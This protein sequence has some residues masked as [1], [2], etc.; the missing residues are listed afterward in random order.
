M[1]DVDRGTVITREQAQDKVTPERTCAWEDLCLRRSASFKTIYRDVSIRVEK[2]IAAAT[3]RLHACVASTCPELSE[4]CIAGGM[5][6]RGIAG[7]AGAPATVRVRHRDV[8]KDAGASPCESTGHVPGLS[9]RYLLC[10]AVTNGHTSYYMNPC[11]TTWIAPN[12]KT[13]S[14]ARGPMHAHHGAR[15]TTAVHSRTS[16]T[17]CKEKTERPVERQGNAQSQQRDRE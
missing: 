17:L 7:A 4:R 12:Q 10:T 9:P 6:Y 16:A 13:V 11:M 1:A 15:H 14:N 3:H 2:A 5:G 8:E